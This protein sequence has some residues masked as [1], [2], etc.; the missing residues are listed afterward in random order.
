MLDG[1][2]RQQRV[3]FL[4]A[5]TIA[6]RLKLVR[7][8]A[9][10]HGRYP[11]QWTA[12]D[13]EDFVDHLRSGTSAVAYSTARTYLVFRSFVEVGRLAWGQGWRLGPA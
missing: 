5:S 1:W 7:R 8:L 9:S 13:I 2:A 4:K 3:R 12:G 6:S 10:T 11:W